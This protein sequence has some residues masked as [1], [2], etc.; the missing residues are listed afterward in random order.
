MS[1][2]SARQIDNNVFRLSTLKHR[3][4]RLAGLQKKT[5]KGKGEKPQRGGSR[6]TGSSST[7][8]VG[9]GEPLPPELSAYPHLRPLEIVFIA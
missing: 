8:T 4:C 5:E 1:G 6:F 7:S 3:R 2:Y 9:H